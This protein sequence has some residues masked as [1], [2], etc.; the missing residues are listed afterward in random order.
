MGKE[1]DLYDYTG[2][3]GLP[4]LVDDAPVGEV[5]KDNGDR[6]TRNA[7]VAVTLV[8]IVG[9]AGVL[10]YEHFVN[11]RHAGA[12]ETPTPKP[13]LTAVPTPVRTVTPEAKATATPAATKSPEAKP[14]AG[15]TE[16]SG[17]KKE[18]ADAKVLPEGSYMFTLTPMPGE[19]SNECR[20][21][22]KYPYGHCSLGFSFDGK[23]I[24]PE[25]E[26]PVYDNFSEPVVIKTEKA[27]V[28]ALNTKPSGKGRETVGFSVLTWD[29]TKYVLSPRVLID[30]GKPTEGG[31]KVLTA[32][33]SDTAVAIPGDGRMLVAYTV[34][35]SD[36]QQPENGR[37]I[38]LMGDKTERAYVRIFD[39]TK[40]RFGGLNNGPIEGE[41]RIPIPDGIT[42]NPSLFF[43]KS[44]K[45]LYIVEQKPGTED[46]RLR[47]VDLGTS[48]EGSVPIEGYQLGLTIPEGNMLLLHNEQRG[49][50]NGKF[51]HTVEF[52]YYDLSTGLI[53]KI[54]FTEEKGRLVLYATMTSDGKKLLVWDTA[55]DESIPPSDS[56]LVAYVPKLTVYELMG[57][58]LKKTGEGGDDPVLGKSFRDRRQWDSEYEPRSKVYFAPAINPETYQLI[59]KGLKKEMSVEE[60]KSLYADWVKKGLPDNGMT[61]EYKPWEDK[62]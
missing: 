48:K 35:S 21:G 28:V 23:P 22:G 50:T 45:Y 60:F 31:E 62:G 20:I 36:G 18:L 10:G 53:K 41:V 34:N 15:P 2:P 38:K 37:I 19:F 46:I 30:S 7:V 4:P 56:S 32:L 42:S 49:M 17:L 39:L 3:A 24:K 1:D 33:L 51:A 12:N 57:G 9:M 47:K 8:V 61:A 13:T 5:K 16:T 25:G 14:T 27:L 58:V 44:A 59:L 54:P 52:A 43:D 55:I 26:T 11:P 40:V 29:G 6:N